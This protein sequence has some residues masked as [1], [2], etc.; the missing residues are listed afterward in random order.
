MKG[1]LLNTHKGV[2]D[3]RVDYLFTKIQEKTKKHYS[4]GVYFTRPELQYIL[5]FT[6]FQEVLK[7]LKEKGFINSYLSP[8]KGK[9]YKEQNLYFI[10]LS[11]SVE[12]TKSGILKYDVPFICK[13]IKYLERHEKP[14]NKYTKI[15]AKN[16]SVTTLHTDNE[17]VNKEFSLRAKDAKSNVS[18]DSFAGRVYSPVTN[19][20][21]TDRPHLR[22]EDERTIEIDLNTSQ[23]TFLSEL[24]LC[25]IGLNSYSEL[26]NSEIDIYKYI[27]TKLKIKTR[28]QAKIK[29]AK[30]IMGRPDSKSANQFY[31]LFPDTENFLRSIKTIPLSENKLR[32]PYKNAA[33]LL[34]SIELKAFKDVW[35]ELNKNN[36]R[37]IS[38]H[39]SVI[40]KKSDLQKGFGIIKNTLENYIS[41]EAKL[42]IK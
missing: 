20:K 27:Q 36:I 4:N 19:L 3:I 29:Y 28:E 10:K 33:Y 26:I 39:D 13:Y 18:L 37:F 17:E 34:Q 15:Q 9:Y 30:M 24:F 12:V 35:K 32:T 42:T 25:E 22:I 2:R 5:G 1:I 16:I 21:R 11:D 38:V 14:Q 31:D 40:I 23:P 6:H 8:R 7:Q 41:I